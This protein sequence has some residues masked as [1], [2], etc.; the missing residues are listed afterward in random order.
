MLVSGVG[1]GVGVG[2]NVGVGVGVVMVSES[3]SVVALMSSVE[4]SVVS[5]TASP[6]RPLSCA[7]NASLRRPPRPMSADGRC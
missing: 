2:V 5:D 7:F 3:V 6:I 4:D 1:V